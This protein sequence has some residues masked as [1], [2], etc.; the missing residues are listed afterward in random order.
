MGTCLV[1]DAC[2]LNLLAHG[3]PHT[4]PNPHHGA[5]SKNVSNRK[6]KAEVNQLLEILV[7]SLYS[8]KEIFLRELI[9]NASDALDKA[10]FE[11]A[12]G[13]EL[14]DPSLEP[15][16][17][18]SVDAEARTLTVADTGI[19]MT[20]DEVVANLGT[21]A[22]SGTSAFIKAAK[23]AQQSADADRDGNGD[24]PRL[25]SIIGQ[26]GVG[27]YSAFMVADSVSVTTRSATDPNATPVRWSSNG[28]ESY[29]IERLT[30]DEAAAVTRGTAVTVHLREDDAKYADAE[31]VRGVIRRH[32]G[33]VS[34][35]VLVEGERVNTVS[36]LW[37]EPAHQV[38]KEQYTEFYQ[39]LTHDTRDP[40]VT[41][42]K[43]SDAPIHF[44][45][46]LFAPPSGMDL[47]GG[48]QGPEGLD[49]YVRRVLI[50]QKNTDILP[51][52]LGFF[53][54]VVDSEDLPLNISRETLQ[55][56]VLL[57]KIGQSVTKAVLETL[58]KLAKKDAEAYAEFWRA[59]G[60]IFKLG[61]ADFANKDR[62]AELVRFTSSTQE[63]PEDSPEDGSEPLVGL[64]DYV[65]RARE[66]QDEIYYL[67]GKSRAAIEANPHLDKLRD[68]GL[69][70]L[71][72]YEAVD[73]FVLDA[74]GEYEGK[75]LVSAEHADPAKLDELS[76]KKPDDEPEQSE[77]EKGAVNALVERMKSVLGERVKDVRTSGRLSG[78]PVVLAG[79]G[80][81]MTSSMEK[82]LRAMQK[83][84]SAPVKV[85]EVNPT[86][87]IVT[88]VAAALA[89]GNEAYVDTAIW[90]LFESAQLLD[91]HLPDPHELVRHMQDHL[92]YSSKGT[93]SS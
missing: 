29:K 30:G 64:A 49:L 33:F 15:A 53:R 90:Q 72:L 1:Y 77:D 91:G 31:T 52:Y 45:T 78:S 71:Y 35:P 38:S 5:M 36:A 82:I 70:V 85:L 42:H 63:V 20:E 57:R 59:H 54:G 27:F 62:F 13:T 68:A 67:S 19:G 93:A 55:E 50:Q 3:P 24:G 47:F 87:E 40:L 58:K 9:A 26:F 73:D 21:I 41:V 10:R 88:N 25:E 14:T 7:H 11:A 76:G 79:E 89:A 43:T 34:H 37:R 48:Y 56:N 28:K 6:F 75:K 39:F 44:A 74:I 2:L 86:H 69:E 18:I 81:Q 61:Y 92:R 80:G 66:G 65:S 60:A 83:D 16:I 12:R 4:N 8:N 84:E 22:H 51:E 23:E 32:S 17:T 46:L